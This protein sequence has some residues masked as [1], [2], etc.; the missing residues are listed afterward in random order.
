MLFASKHAYISKHKV[1]A[2]IVAPAKHAPKDLGSVREERQSL[3][4]CSSIS[5]SELDKSNSD[6]NSDGETKEVPKKEE[7][8]I[9]MHQLAPVKS[10]KKFIPPTL[11]I[12]ANSKA[13]KSLER[14][15]TGTTKAAKSQPKHQNHPTML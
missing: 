7:L 6:S 4:S 3:D 9:S 12:E 14:K 10:A 1:Q 11:P 8:S 15:Y 13:K 2:E 5:D